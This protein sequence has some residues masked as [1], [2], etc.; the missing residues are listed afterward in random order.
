MRKTPSNW[1]WQRLKLPQSDCRGLR[2]S[3]LSSS[4]SCFFFFFFPSSFLQSHIALLWRRAGGRGGGGASEADSLR[5]SDVL[6]LYSLGEGVDNAVKWGD[7]AQRERERERE[8]EPEGSSLLD[9]HMVLSWLA[10]PPLSSSPLTAPRNPVL[11]H[12]CQ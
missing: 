8:R 10:S 4:T 12:L 6:A 5:K 1:R 2:R 7:V 3:S 11:W 9:M